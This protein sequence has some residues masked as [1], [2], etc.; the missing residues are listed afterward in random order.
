MP[1]PDDPIH[2]LTA[3]DCQMRELFGHLRDRQQGDGE[4]ER[5][6]AAIREGRL[7]AGVVVRN[8]RGL[9]INL[10]ARQAFV[11]AGGTA[12]ASEGAR[13]GGRPHPWHPS[14]WQRFAKAPRANAA[15]RHQST[16]APFA[17][18]TRR[19]GSLGRRH[20]SHGQGTR[21]VPRL[22]GDEGW[23]RLRERSPRLVPRT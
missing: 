16:V 6:D 23:L 20:L 2:R 4:T 21:G 22:P 12:A 17:P 19:R 1:V 10:T 14:D 3:S 11:E 7:P 9:A 8:G 15:L 5:S 18:N 13:G